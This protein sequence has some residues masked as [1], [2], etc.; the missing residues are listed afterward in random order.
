MRL[1]STSIKGVQGLDVL[2]DTARSLND[3]DPLDVVLEQLARA[4]GRAVWHGS[5]KP[6][7]ASLWRFRGSTLSLEA[8]TE[9]V[10]GSA[11]TE[12]PL[13]AELQQALDARQ[14]V[15]LSGTQLPASLRER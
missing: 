14:A 12:L 10:R 3:G 7:M 5:G 8:E 6:G 15:R 1:E 9:D 2:L 11:L 13:S 4:A